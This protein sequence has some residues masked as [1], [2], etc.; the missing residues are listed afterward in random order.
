MSPDYTS[1]PE[2]PEDRNSRWKEL[3]SEIAAENE[4]ALSRLYDECNGLVYS[5][6][7]KILNDKQ[8]AEEVTLD[9][10]KYLWENASKY[11][12]DRSNPT[13][14]I[15]ML[16][17]SRSIDRIRSRKNKEVATDIFENEISTSDTETE[18]PTVMSQ[19]RKIVTKALS[20]LSRKQKNVV[21][22]AYFYQYTHSEI[23]EKLDMPLGSVK[24]AIRL[25]TE[26]LKQNLTQLK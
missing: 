19:E 23:A 16:T 18:R 1:E 10:F 2:N 7:L 12:D 26:K 3:I 4:S 25:A 22:L 9:V 20:E 6:A 5:L 17:R 24:S 8:D 13:T 15:V 11:R 21:E 14:W